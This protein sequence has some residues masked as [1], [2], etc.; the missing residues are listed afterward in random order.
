MTFQ[1]QHLATGELIWIYDQESG[2]LAFIRD[3][4][5]FGSREQATQFALCVVDERGDRY[6]VAEGGALV[7]RALEDRAP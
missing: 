5:R 7:T 2:A 6:V 4:V 3:V 1:L